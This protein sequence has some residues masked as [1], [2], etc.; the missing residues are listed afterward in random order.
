MQ[1]D[2]DSTGQGR[3][4]VADAAGQAAALALLRAGEAVALPTETVYGL[5]ADATQDHAV[6]RIFEIKQ[7]PKLNPL[8]AHYASL[9][10][11]RADVV[12]SPQ[13]ERLAQHF[14]PGPLTL[15]LPRSAE[16]RLSLLCSAG[17]PTAAIRVPDH[18]VTRGLIRELGHPLAAPSANRSGGLSPTTPE[19]VVHS[20]GGDVPLILAGGKC[21]TG[22][23]SSVLDLSGESPVLLRPG[24]I[25]A[26]QISA[27]L[28]CPVASHFTAGAGEAARSPGQLYRHY[29]PNKP[30]RLEAREARA[31]EAYLAFGPN[32]FC[33]KG[34]SVRL[35]LSPEGD[36][37]EAAANLFALLHRLDAMPDC[38]AIAVAPLPQEG[39][40]LAIYDRLH[41]AAAAQEESTASGLPFNA[42]SR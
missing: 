11:A 17:L 33:G 26:Q 19:H 29:A 41:K 2:R 20:L 42:E 21:R 10:E 25:S 39:L 3:I 24:A 4:M 15:I 22:L 34:A 1:Q 38:T 14:W 36:L 32:P 28:G 8:I 7:R 37:T 31:G 35:N 12:L 30:L 9:E 6:A 18:A 16:S 40:G 27:V 23:E 13:A 5:A